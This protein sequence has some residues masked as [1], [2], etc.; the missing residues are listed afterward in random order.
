MSVFQILKNEVLIIDGNL[1]YTDSVDNFLT[2]AERLLPR[3]QLCMTM[4]RNAAWLTGNFWPIPTPPIVVIVTELVIY[5]MPE[6]NVPTW[7]RQNRQKR[8]KRQRQRPA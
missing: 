3:T 7:L 4:H 2:D 8:N 5:W 6:Q 1:S